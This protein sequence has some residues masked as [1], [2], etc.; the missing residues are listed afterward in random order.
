MTNLTD[1]E[2][3]KVA[4]VN[5]LWRNGLLSFKLDT[6]QKELYE[7]YYNSTHKIMTWLLSRRQGKTYTLCV[8]A[9]EQ[10]IRKP[11]SV[12]KLVSPTKVQVNNN[13]RPIFR[14]LLEDCPE[15]IRPEFRQKEYIFF[16]KN[17]SE[18]QLAGSDSGH[19]EKLRGGDSDI[20]MVDEAGS[21]DDLKNMVKSI[22]LPTTLITQGKGIL[23]STPPRESDHEFLYYIEEAEQRGSLIKKTIDD[24]PRITPEQKQELIQE[25]GGSNTEE[26]RREL[27]CEIIKDS[28]SSVIPEFDTA[29]EKEIV[30]EW[31][32]PPFYDAY[33]GMDTGGKD[34]T[35]VLYGYFDFRANKIVIEDETVINFQE[36]DQTIELLAKEINKKE[37]VLWTNPISGEYKQPHIRVSDIS[38]ILTQ[39][40]YNHS[41]KLFPKEETIGFQVAK[42]DDADAMI[43]NLRILLGN[44]QIIIHPRCVTLIR[45]LKNVRW[46]KQRKGFARSADDGHYDAVE[47][48]KYLVR[49]IDY[50]KNPYP[51]HYQMNMS[52][53]FVRDPAKFADNSNTQLEKYKQIFGLR[54]K[55]KF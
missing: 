14:Q 4:A 44:K 20:W 10:C 39:E 47:A 55:R 19:A 37:K 26:A 45:H 29:L 49:V 25:L 8:L 27:Y 52:G 18:I 9:L 7:L 32:K 15:D 34:L 17:G 54:S 13:V 40:I 30:K 1:K 53:M 50:K 46:D 41:R 38:Y 43:N 24:N 12:V 11:N 35:V 21:C 51:A 2:L 23:A 22:L 16:F 33:E 36:R 3:Q 6:T 42:K 31:P 28:K 5:Q 48:L